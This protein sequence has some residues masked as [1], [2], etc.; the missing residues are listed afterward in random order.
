MAVA[1]QVTRLAPGGLSHHGAAGSVA[2]SLV[3]D[4]LELTGLS[5]DEAVDQAPPLPGVADE[6]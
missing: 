5:H 3:V 6:A 1:E 2:R 4:L